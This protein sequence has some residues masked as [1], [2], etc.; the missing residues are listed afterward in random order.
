MKTDKVKMVDTKNV[1][2][3]KL[4]SLLT[5]LELLKKPARKTRY[6]II[7]VTGF[8]V[9]IRISGCISFLQVL[10]CLLRGLRPGSSVKL[11]KVIYSAWRNL[12][13]C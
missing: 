9:C 5:E 11:S 13:Y 4:F 7:P 12:R 3:L 6:K 10:I 2:P 1:S 8:S